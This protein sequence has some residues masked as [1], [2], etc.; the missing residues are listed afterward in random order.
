MVT[1][2]WTDE[3][4]KWLRRIFDYISEDSRENAYKVIAGIIE[5]TEILCSFPEIGQILTDWTD[6]EIRMI[7][8]GHYRM[9]YRIRSSER[10]DILGV[11]HAALDLKRH[12]KT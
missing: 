9:V 7:L 11:Y 5:R 10:I 6:L 3:S 12:L 2:F 1:I 8:Y 4:R